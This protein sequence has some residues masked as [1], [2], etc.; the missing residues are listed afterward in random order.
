MIKNII[1][2]SKSEIRKKI[3]ENNGIKC[4][5]I[6][7]EINEEQIETWSWDFGDDG[8]STEQNPTHTYENLGEY[9]VSLTVTDD[10]PL[11]L[12]VCDMHAG[13]EQLYGM[14]YAIRTF[15][16]SLLDL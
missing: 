9:T 6:P 13:T 5:V 4:E 12:P 3:L 15:E 2:A 1:L 11:C 10:T 7:A 16:E 14:L 8:S